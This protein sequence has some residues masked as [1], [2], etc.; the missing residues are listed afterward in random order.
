MKIKRRHIVAATIGLAAMGAIT[1]VALASP[2]AGVS[3]TFL[4]TSRL[5]HKVH[6]NADRIKFQTKVAT[7]VRVQSLTF[8]V[9]GQTGWHHHP[10]IVLVAVQ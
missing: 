3:T 5:D 1:P 10:G 8:A 2:G 4:V 7:D 9:G 6:L